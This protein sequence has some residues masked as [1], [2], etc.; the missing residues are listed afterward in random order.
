MYKE[1]KVS[2]KANDISYTAAQRSAA[3]SNLTQI[4]H[5]VTKKVGLWVD[6]LGC[7]RVS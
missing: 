2:P 5:Q 4:Q 1:T 6:E 7:T 3:S